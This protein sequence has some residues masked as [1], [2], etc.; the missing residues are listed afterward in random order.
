MREWPELTPTTDEL[1]VIEETV[2]LLTEDSKDGLLKN[3]HRFWLLFNRKSGLWRKMGRREWIERYVRIRDK[4][5][6]VVP[7]VLNDAQRRLEAMML[8]MERKGLPVR[9]II[10]KARQMGFSTYAAAVLYEK[11]VRES[12]IR[13][14]IVAHKKDTAE[15]LLDMLHTARKYMPRGERLWELKE[16]SKAVYK[17][18][19][20]MPIESACNVTSAEVDEPGH[21]I[22]CQAVNMSETSRWPDAF[23]KAKGIL[24]IL[25]ERAGT[26]AFSESTANGASGWFHDEFNA[27]WE[28]RVLPLGSA[29][30]ESSW[31]AMFYPWFHHNEYRW[32]QTFG[33]GQK[34][35]P[36]E[37]TV[38]INTSLDKEETW[39][40]EQ[41]YLRPGFGMVRVDIDQLAWRRMTIKSKLA[42]VLSDFNEQYPSR[43]ELAFLASGNPAYDLGR[44][45]DILKL[46]S[47]PEHK[48]IW[49]GEISD[50]RPVS[51][52]SPLELLQ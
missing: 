23:R 6:N 30:R 18:R 21:G 49:T 3:N 36:L 24:Q 47:K 50:T 2:S 10:L 13:A 26:L 27:A 4:D 52:S 9:V 11:L 35:L 38:K 14:L 51:V 33:R 19:W 31:V 39:L 44:I 48:P 8:K 42:N 25:P 5:A 7:L 45:Q 34:E 43:P 12:N 22:T 15:S 16:T 20:D 29:Q 28:Q 37:L 17:L 46:V 32:T 41:E 40:L 1:L